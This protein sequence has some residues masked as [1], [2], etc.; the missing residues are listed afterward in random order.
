MCNYRNAIV[1]VVAT[2]SALACSDAP[3]APVQ[4]P[5]AIS[6][7]RG[8]GGGPLTQFYT[9]GIQSEAFAVNAYFQY[10]GKN[11]PSLIVARTAAFDTSVAGTVVAKNMNNGYWLARLEHLAP[12]TQYYLKLTDGTNTWLGDAR[13]YRRRVTIDLD[14]VHV[15]YDGDAGFPC[16]EMIFRYYVHTIPSN[17]KTEF[18][19]TK[20]HDVCSGDDITMSDAEGRYV[21]DD[22]KSNGLALDLALF[23]SDACWAWE[24]QCGQF[25]NTQTLEYDVSGYASYIF[26]LSTDPSSGAQVVWEG[27]VKSTFVPW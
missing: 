19:T 26:K 1:A 17:Y 18:Y 11:T 24:G 25:S 27:T 4:P 8:A 7:W 16:G 15:S 22:W 2:C 14:K 6:A 5:N 21:L 20:W 9:V 23:E 13:T 12:G 3:T 10:G